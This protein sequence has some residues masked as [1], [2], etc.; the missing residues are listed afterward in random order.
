MGS[1]LDDV[2]LAHADD[3][4]CA[5][6][7]AESVCD[8]DHCLLLL[9]E[10]SVQGLLDLVLAVSVECASSLVKKK[11]PW[12]THKG[13][14]NGNALLLSTRES[15][16]PLTD[17]GIEPLREQLLVIEEAAAGLLQGNLQT[18]IYFTLCKARLIKAI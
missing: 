3:L 14:G 17:L 1:L 12:S 18:L 8:H 9:L 2:T 4:V 15:H 6:D 11:D 13:S 7:C 16:A 5:D 10:Q